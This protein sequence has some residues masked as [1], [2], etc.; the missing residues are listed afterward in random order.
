MTVQDLVNSIT[1]LNRE[2][3]GISKSLSSLE[4]N[5]I[6][7]L[8][9]NSS[10][11]ITIIQEMQKFSD[12]IK[13][14]GSNLKLTFIRLETYD[15]KLGTA[16]ESIKEIIGKFDTETLVNKLKT[17]L[18]DLKVKLA[19][20]CR[21]CIVIKEVK[22]NTDKLVHEKEKWLKWLRPIVILL[23][24][25]IATLLGLNASGVIKLTIPSLGG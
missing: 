5:E 23:A 6:E 15:E 17:Q 13:D 10:F 11:K 16:L 18:V 14:F 4:D 9:N 1:N 12:V 22:E 2:L 24:S 7:A 21:D 3:D 19:D 20:E 8:K 25:I